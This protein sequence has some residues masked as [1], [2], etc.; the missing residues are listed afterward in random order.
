MAHRD[1]AATPDR[2]LDARHLTE[3]LRRR[4]PEE[5]E[6]VAQCL[7]LENDRADVA[8]ALGITRGTLSVRLHRD[9]A[10]LRSTL[11]TL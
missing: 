1:G 4:H 8:R 9:V 10:R 5:L 3:L 2:R 7:V 11:D 6:L